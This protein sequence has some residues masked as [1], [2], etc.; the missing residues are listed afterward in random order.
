MSRRIHRG[1]LVWACAALLS[2]RVAAAGPT[3]NLYSPHPAVTNRFEGISWPK[4]Q[5]LPTFATPAPVLDCLEVQALTGDEPITFS[6]LQGL[7][8]RQQPRI[9]LVDARAGE[10]PDT[11]ADTATVGPGQ[12]NSIPAR[13]NTI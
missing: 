5:A 2:G 7:V 12:E 9:Y 1:A 11:W 4:G 8:N 6:A 13:T 3:Q 10:G